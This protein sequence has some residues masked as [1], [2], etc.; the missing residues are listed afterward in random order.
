[1]TEH[2][3]M[4]PDPEEIEVEAT[5]VETIDG[6]TLDRLADYLAA[7][8]EPADPTIESSAAC[9]LYLAA[10][11]RLQERSWAALAREAEREP[12]RDDVWIDGLLTSIRSEVR[13]GRDIPVSGPDSRSEL[14]LTEGAVKGIIRRAVDAVGGV[15]LGRC[16]LEGDVTEP[17]APIAVEVTAAAA[18]DQDLRALADRLRRMVRS[19]LDRHTE[20]VITSIDVTID[21]VYVAGEGAS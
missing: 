6:H 21:D 8:R 13:S 20:L 19:E 11:T 2:D 17:G 16:T 18:H 7:G 5:E 4:T 15:I 3:D 9:R 12:D 1:M 14:S 10:L